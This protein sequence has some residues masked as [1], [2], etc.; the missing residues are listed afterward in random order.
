MCNK[1]VFENLQCL[2]W[3]SHTDSTLADTKNVSSL[4]NYK[5]LINL[6][7]FFNYS[8]SL[9]NTEMFGK[10]KLTVSSEQLSVESQP[11]TL[12]KMDY[13][14]PNVSVISLISNDHLS[15]GVIKFTFFDD[16]DT[17]VG[18]LGINDSAN[19]LNNLVRTFPCLFI[20]LDECF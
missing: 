6:S 1:I 10:Y 20:T 4:G 11:V 19:N 2:E 15:D 8:D 12:K 13:T 17:S 18:T 7:G 16:E 5:T 3:D 9:N 14:K